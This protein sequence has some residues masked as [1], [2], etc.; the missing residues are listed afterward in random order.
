MVMIY[1]IAAF[2]LSFLSNMM[3][4]KDEIPMISQSR[5]NMI[6][7]RAQSKPC[8]LSPSM[9]SQKRWDAVPF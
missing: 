8:M 3:A 2:R 7:W 9:P 5:R 6:L 4:K 1:V